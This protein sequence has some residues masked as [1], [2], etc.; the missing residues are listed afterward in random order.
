MEIKCQSKHQSRAS[1]PGNGHLLN[2]KTLRNHEDKKNV[3][4]TH[5]A[6]LR[7]YL[8]TAEVQTATTKAL[9]SQLS[10]HYEEPLLMSIIDSF[11]LHYF[12]GE[13]NDAFVQAIHRHGASPSMMVLPS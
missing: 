6:S 11:V 9:N 12:G 8:V 3:T 7:P 5:I 2:T 10:K 4:I 1:E 13:Y